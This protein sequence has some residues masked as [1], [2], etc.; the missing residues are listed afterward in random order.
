MTSSV[1]AS[2]S[3]LSAGI[4]LR[5]KASAAS[6]VSRVEVTITNIP[7]FT[8]ASAPGRRGFPPAGGQG[9]GKRPA[10]TTPA[11]AGGPED[12]GAATIP[13]G[14]GRSRTVGRTG[15]P[16][17]II[18]PARHCSVRDGSVTDRNHAKTHAGR[19]QL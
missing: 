3:F 10:D 18:P 15:R 14:A 19:E 4:G 12:E 16:P 9:Q 17:P 7:S 5:C 8:V 11:G 2:A 6:D 1:S 13:V